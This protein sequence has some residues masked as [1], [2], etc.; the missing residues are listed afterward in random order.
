MLKC[1][2]TGACCDAQDPGN[3]DSEIFKH[4][5]VGISYEGLWSMQVWRV[6][7]STYHKLEC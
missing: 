7:D 2:T 5:A 1:S 6:V 4:P 3:N